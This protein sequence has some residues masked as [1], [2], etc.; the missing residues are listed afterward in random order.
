[1]SNKLTITN[2]SSFTNNFLNTIGK[3]VEDCI[4]NVTPSSLNS[5]GSTSDGTLIQ[6]VKFKNENNFNQSLNVPDIKRLHKI[7]SCIGTESFSLDINDNCISYK[8]PQTRFKFYLLDDGILSPPPIS[9]EKIKKLEYDLEFVLPHNKIQELVKGSTFS[10]ESEKLYLYTSEGYIYGELTDRE[11]PNMDSF[12]I[13]LTDE[14]IS[15]VSFQPL[16]FNF[17]NIRIISSTR[18]EKIKFSINTQMSVIRVDIPLDDCY[19]T[20]IVS[21]LIK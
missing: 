1:M 7:I 17:E 12:C 20:Y 14:P 4:I 19:I 13:R 10:N 6:Y 8:S 11:K 9:I 18:C 16:P 2:S 21:A 3:V 5:L 15:N